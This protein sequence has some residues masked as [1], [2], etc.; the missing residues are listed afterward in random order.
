MGKLDSDGNVKVSYDDDDDDND[1]N[2]MMMMMMFDLDI[3]KSEGE[4][5]WG[6]KQPTEPGH[7][8]I[9][10]HHPCFIFVIIMTIVMII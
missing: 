5:T 6:V 9:I 10:F 7:Q 1:D 3:V 2:R 8:I 4:K